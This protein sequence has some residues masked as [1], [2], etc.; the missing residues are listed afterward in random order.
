MVF[1]ALGVVLFT[2][3]FIIGA[4]QIYFQNSQY[5]YHAEAALAIAEAGVDKALESLNKSSGAYSGEEEVSLGDGSYSVTI[6]SKDASTKVIQATAYIPDK[7]NAKAQ[8]KITILVSKGVGIAF[9]YGL[10]IGQGGLAMGNSATL[11]GSIYSNGNIS[12]GNS[13]TIS[14]DVFVAGGVQTQADQQSD[15]TDNN[16]QDYI[17]GKSVMGENRLDVAQSFKPGCL[18]PPICKMDINKISIKIKKNGNPP[19]ATVRIMTDTSG[20]PNK[21]EVLANGVLAANLISSQFSLIDVTF[22]ATPRINADT[23]YW[24]VVSAKSLDLVNYWHLSNDLA[25]GYNGGLPKWSANWQARTPVWS[26]I[27]G[28]LA[29]KTFMGGVITS[30]DLGNG[31]KIL[32]SVH[33]NTIK[34]DLTIEGNAYFQTLGSQVEVK[35]TKYPDSADSPPT[36]FPISLANITDWK[37]QAEESAVTEGSMSFGNDCNKNLGPGQITGSV[38]FGNGCRVTIKSPVWIKGALS[39][40]NNTIFTLDQSFGGASGL[41][42]VDGATS[43]GNGCDL[44]GSG[45]DGSYLMLLS[46]SDG[47]AMD[48]GNSSISGIVYAPNGAVDLSNGASFKEI[49]AN[50][51]IL[52]NSAVLNYETGLESTVFSAGPSGAFSLVKGTYQVK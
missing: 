1:I 3:L 11:N 19:N 38:S 34:G 26:E 28:D 4:S 33:G 42:I 43:M 31:S 22:D 14:G 30:V 51:I 9:N 21:N 2:V 23:T 17:F 5:A 25:K 45:T 32:G 18:N 46:T 13:A 37:N 44:R 24:I 52:G 27:D 10:Q 47:T 29:F 8:R 48:L 20:A 12:A 40:G 35:G 41:I 6:I 7:A 16:C 36:V 50:Q 49:V 15:C 39:T